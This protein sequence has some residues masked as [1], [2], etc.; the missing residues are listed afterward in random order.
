VNLGNEI[1]YSIGPPASGAILAYI[2][3]ILKHY[4]IGPNDENPLMYHRVA[5]S[6]KW[7]Y[8]QR[9][10]LGDPY[11]TDITSFVNEV[12]FSFIVGVHK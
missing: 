4:N 8:A 5:E 9:S 10:K 2:M 3:N 1:L 11:D 7:A 6:F 12:G